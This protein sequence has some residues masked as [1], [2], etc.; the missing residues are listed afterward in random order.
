MRELC[1]ITFASSRVSQLAGSG[2]SGPHR[3]R[4][5]PV[6]DRLTQISASTTSTQP[7][8]RSDEKPPLG[9]GAAL[10]GHQKMRKRP[11]DKLDVKNIIRVLERDVLNMSRAIEFA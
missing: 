2:G 9:L 10:Q 4:G 3:T 1:K 7:L 8:T 5:K 11:A 6:L